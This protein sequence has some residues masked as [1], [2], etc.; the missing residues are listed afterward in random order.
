MN[1][2]TVTLILGPDHAA[3]LLEILAEMDADEMYVFHAMPAR[4]QFLTL[5]AQ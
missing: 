3:N 5:L 2:T 4:R 1:D